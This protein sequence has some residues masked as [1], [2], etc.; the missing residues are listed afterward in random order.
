MNINPLIETALSN[1]DCPIAPIK[2]EG[3]VD[4][5]IVYY[6]YS[7]NPELF[8][9]DE[10]IAEATYGTVMIYSKVNFKAIATNVKAK[11]RQAGFTIRS[12]GPEGYESDTGYYSWPIEIYIE[13]GLEE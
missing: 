1:I 11:L 9:D 7:E 10:T 5:Y 3:T 8:A 13:E 2:H 6:T 4:T 12:A